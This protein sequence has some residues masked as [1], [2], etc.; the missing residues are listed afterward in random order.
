MT[1]IE[2]EGTT[3]DYTTLLRTLR[4]NIIRPEPDLFLQKITIGVQS[5]VSSDFC[6][7][8][9]SVIEENDNFPLLDLNG[10]LQVSVISNTHS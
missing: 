6:T 1:Q 7:I 3:N 5:R 2:G 4:F 9:I 10:P 8:S